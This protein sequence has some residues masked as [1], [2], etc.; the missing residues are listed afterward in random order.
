MRG[1]IDD[2]KGAEQT[3]HMPV[4]LRQC[5]SLVDLAWSESTDNTRHIERTAALFGISDRP[6][7]PTVQISSSRHIGLH[8]RDRWFRVGNVWKTALT[9]GAIVS[10]AS[11][12]VSVRRGSADSIR[13]SGEKTL[14]QQAGYK[15]AICLPVTTKSVLAFREA[16][17]QAT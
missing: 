17:L 1:E 6:P 7:R 9:N 13:A 5:H 4:A 10:A 8:P 11:S 2:R 3:G 15:T 12:S 16:S 14:H